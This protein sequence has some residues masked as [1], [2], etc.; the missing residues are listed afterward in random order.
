MERDSDS[1]ANSADGKEDGKE[2]DS[3]SAESSAMDPEDVDVTCNSGVA[4]SGF[5]LSTESTLEPPNP[6]G[7]VHGC[8]PT[9]TTT[10][11]LSQLV[12]T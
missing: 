8:L 3:D 12:P 1:A 11:A 5:C 7:Y 9:A 2:R 4:V 6:S 10:D